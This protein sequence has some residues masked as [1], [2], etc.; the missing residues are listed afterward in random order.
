MGKYAHLSEL[1]VIIYV[2]QLLW[3][4]CNCSH[5]LYNFV[6]FVAII[7]FCNLAAKSSLCCWVIRRILEAAYMCHALC[8]SCSSE[9]QQGNGTDCHWCLV[10]FAIPLFDGDMWWLFVFVAVTIS[11]TIHVTIVCRKL[12]SRLRILMLLSHVKMCM[13]AGLAFYYSKISECI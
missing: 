4:S 11:I 10:C 7:T 13:S 6:L 1:V 5:K 8:L 9:L 12:F 3:M 2:T